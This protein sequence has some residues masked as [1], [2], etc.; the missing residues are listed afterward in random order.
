[1]HNYRHLHYFPVVAEQDGIAAASEPLHSPWQPISGQISLLKASRGEN[2]FTKV[3]R[4]LELTE[5]GRLVPGCAGEIF[6]LGGELKDTVLADSPIFTV[7][8]IRGFNSMIGSSDGMRERFQAVS[9]ERKIADPA[10]AAITKTAPA[11][12]K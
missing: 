12:L 10:V 7:V 2:L 8:N 4:K 11:W 6:P 9:V 3:G 1:M 5:V